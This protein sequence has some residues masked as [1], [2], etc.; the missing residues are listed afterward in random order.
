MR[1]PEWRNGSWTVGGGHRLFKDVGGRMGRVSIDLYK[2]SNLLG[3]VNKGYELANL[4]V[5]QTGGDSIQTNFGS[6]VLYRC[7]DE[8]GCGI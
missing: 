3:G 8:G 1:P 2:Q 7:Q 5:A 6:N 4:R